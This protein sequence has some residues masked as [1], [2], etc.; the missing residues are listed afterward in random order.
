MK[1]AILFLSFL[2]G[3]SS[4]TQAQSVT[5]TNYYV[6]T[7]GGTRFSKARPQGQCD[8]K[9][10]AAYS[11]KVRS[12]ACAFGKVSYIAFDGAYSIVPKYVIAGGDVV[13]IGPGQFRCG[14]NGPKATD[15]DGISIAGNPYGSCFPN[16]P[17]GTADHPTTFIGA[18]INKTQIYAGYGAGSI[19]AISNPYITIENMELTDHGQCSRTGK[20]AANR[21]MCNSSYPLDDY[22]G[23]GITTNTNAHDITLT[24]LNIHGFVARGIIGPIGGLVTA[25]HVRIA[26]NGGGGWDFDNGSGTKSIN[27]ATVNASYLVVEGNGFNEEY[28]IVHPA[29]PAFN[30]SDQN[31]AGYGDGIATPNT[32]LNFTCDHCTIRYNTQDGLDLLHTSGSVTKVTNSTS[33]GNMGQQWK[34]GSMTSVVFRNNTTI[35]NCSRLS[36]PMPG[37]SA[38]YNLGLTLFCRAAGDGFGLNV[39]DGGTYLFQNN[40]FVG[41]GATT[42]DINCAGTQANIVFQNNLHIGY[43]NPTDGQYP[44]IFYF[45]HG[46]P[47]NPFKANDHN[48]YFHMRSLPAGGIGTDP[49]IANEPVWK[50]EGSLDAVDFHLTA[51]STNALGRGKA[52]ADLTTDFSGAPRS[53]T[54]PSIGAYEGIGSNARP[55]GSADSTAPSGNGT[56]ATTPG[57]TTWAK[58]A[59]EGQTV[60]LPP[61]TTY[62]YGAGSSWSAPF[63]TGRLATSVTANDATFTN[64]APNAAKE[65]EV[66]VVPKHPSTLASTAAK[67]ICTAS[68]DGRTITETCKP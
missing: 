60:K 59:S 52:I 45:E 67:E 3:A 54:A 23:S 62:R 36:A 16:L 58:I 26:F 56:I 9:T 18:G 50:N 63:T 49:H 21:P 24:N 29:F 17:G 35:H 19:F 57:N 64:V 42:Y 12:H 27:N 34:L 30:G 6:R 4:A 37:A 55:G 46:C 13:H 39:I 22:A 25:N 38:N 7:D 8:G 33:Y 43:K 15:H 5:P 1:I 65:L 53:A 31:N 32:P 11:P 48:I 20:A 10:D 40:S 66:L 28:P 44:G 2:F 51:Q 47:K 68:S 14:Y 61:Y 41:Y